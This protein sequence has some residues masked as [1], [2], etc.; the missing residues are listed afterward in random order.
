MLGITE[1]YEQFD[2]DIIIHI[3]SAFSVLTQLGVG[4]A[5]GFFIED[6]SAVWSDFVDDSRLEMVKS[7][8]YFK[9]RLAFDPPTSSAAMQ[10]INE[11]IS[12]LA[13]RLNVVVD[14]G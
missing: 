2:T 6:S 8:I 7:Y 4:P 13:W 9:V 12:E 3:N 14:P 10:A 1:D 11:Q 5:S